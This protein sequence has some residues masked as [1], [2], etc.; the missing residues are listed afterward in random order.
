M[1][2]NKAAEHLQ[3]IRTLMER[4]AL[5]RRALAPIML[6][7]GILGVLGAAAGIALQLDSIRS[8]GELWLGVAVVAVT[9]AFV[10]ARRQSL[11][12][13]EPFWSPPTRRVGQALLP[14]LVAG[15]L[16]SL[17]ILI[18]NPDHM[19][20]LFIF[21]NVLFYGCALHSAGFFISRGV[22][23]FG[24]ILIVLGCAAL[25]VVPMFQS[26]PDP[27]LDHALM[28]FFFGVL[29]LACG[30]YLYLTEKRKNVA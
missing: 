29:H 19:H 17:V 4:S 22:K 16:F 21:P 30:V 5:Y 15:L 8:F 28:G 24:W 2:S 3:V 13:H 27:R 25:L 1:E 12:D 18:F 20:W 14:P 10:I 7:A 23:L 6:F 26:D 11:K 9:G